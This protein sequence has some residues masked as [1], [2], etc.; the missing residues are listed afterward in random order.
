MRISTITPAALV[1]CAV[2]R[3]QPY[4]KPEVDWAAIEKQ[5]QNS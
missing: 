1:L 5:F 3:S 4:S 2:A